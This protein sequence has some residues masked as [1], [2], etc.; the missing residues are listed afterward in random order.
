MVTSYFELPVL[1]AGV[2]NFISKAFPYAVILF[3]VKTTLLT[4]IGFSVFLGFGGRLDFSTV[5]S[6]LIVVIGLVMMFLAIP[7]LFRR[8]RFSWRLVFYMTILMTLDYLQ[9]SIFG[10]LRSIEYSDETYIASGFL[11]IIQ[12]IF[13]ISV[14]WY[15]LHQVKEIYNN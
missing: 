1:P 2:K 7:G 15:L 8:T 12:F 13:G 10:V 9:I 14:V 6:L 3:L 11:G 4:F 5:T